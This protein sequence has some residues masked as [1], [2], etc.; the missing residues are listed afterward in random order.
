MSGLRAALRPAVMRDH[1]VP[2]RAATPLELLFDLC[3]VVAVAVLAAELHHGL[4]A[5]HALPAAGVYLALFIPIWWAWMSYTW[6][7]T[8]FSHDDP[9][10]RVL[11]LAQM[12]GM[13]AVAATVPAAA[14]GRTGAFTVAYAVMRLPLI[15]QWLR[16]ARDDEV[17]RRF[18]LTYAAGHV[19]AQLT[20]LAALAVEGGARWA[21]YLVALGIE[22]ATPM[23]AV[24]RSPD[25][26]FHPGH[27]AERY[28]LFTLIVLGETLLAVTVGLRDAVEGETSTAAAVLLT[29]PVLII[30]FGV[31]WLYFDALGREGL[32]RNRKAAFVW[33]YGHYLLF[34]A[35]AAIGAGAQAQLDGSAAHG[36]ATGGGT[37]GA[38]HGP[39]ET[40]AVAAIAVPLCLVLLTIVWLQ[41]S[42]NQRAGS[43]PPL[44]FGAAVAVA[45][46]GAGGRLGATAAN[47]VLAVA[48]VIVVVLVARRTEAGT[49]EGSREARGV[50]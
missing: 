26:V 20:W 21:G 35:V 14:Q 16:S 9:A 41:Q 17:H 47:A 22:L 39:D 5:G 30:A 10:T 15:V 32:Q 36:P 27:I 18:A 46:A 48:V 40:V 38:A 34:A 37:E 2:E 19:L 42:A 29:G 6:Y 50:G 49:E 4:S 8:A 31:W 33:G 24:R 13:L 23:S 44:L 43:A 28:G 12:A 25:R 7:A 3:F 45:V 11:T 1:A